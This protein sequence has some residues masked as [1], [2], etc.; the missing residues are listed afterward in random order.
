MGERL[1]PALQVKNAIATMVKSGAL[2]GDKCEA[3][4]KKLEREKVVAEQRARAEAGDVE[5]MKL[6][7]VW[8]EDRRYGLAEDPTMSF[9]WYKRGGGPR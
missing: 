6:L 1:I 2:S 9:S 8:Y 5:A 3:W 4:T 7:G